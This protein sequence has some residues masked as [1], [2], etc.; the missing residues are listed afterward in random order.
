MTRHRAQSDSNSVQLFP[1][2]AVLLCMMGALILLLV[3]IARNARAQAQADGELA[4]PSTEDKARREE[5]D[6]RREQLIAQRDRTQAELSE[7]RLELGHF[8]EHARALRAELNELESARAQLDQ[9]S[10]TDEQ[11]KR[12][13]AARIA[14]LNRQLSETQAKLL[15]ARQKL[16]EQ[17]SSY[18]IIPYLGPNSTNRPPLYIEC[19][20][21]RVILQPEGVVLLSEDFDGPLGPGNPLAAALRAAREH[22]ARNR[23]TNVGEMGEPY[24]LLLVRPDGIMAY[25]MA[26][27][28]LESWGGDFGYELVDADWDLD[29][30][31]PD[32]EL[33]HSEETA[34]AEARIQQRALAQMMPRLQGR[35]ARQYRAS[36]SGGGIVAA[37]ELPEDDLPGYRKRGTAR[38][39][40]SGYFDP[41]PQASPNAGLAAADAWAAN[42][43]SGNGLGF[44]GQGNGWGTPYAA[45][46]PGQGATGGTS[47]LGGNDGGLYPS[48]APLDPVSR[49]GPLRAGSSGSRGQG[50]GD[51][52]GGR[53]AA[54]GTPGDG[55][56]E[57]S[58][59]SSLAASGGAN[60]GGS[61]ETAAGN[62]GMA[63]DGTS[64][65]DAT[66]AGAGNAADGSDGPAL[67]ASGTNASSAGG[68][69]RT[70]ST[71]GSP[72]ASATP[73]RSGQSAATASAT[74][75]L[76]SPF[77]TYGTS[78]ASGSASSGMS[79][80]SAG[81][82]SGSP[83]GAPT[84]GSSSPGAPSFSHTSAP[85]PGSMAQ[86]RGRDWAVPDEVRRAAP[87]T[88]PVLVRCSQSS[89][90]ILDDD[91]SGRQ[92]RAVPLTEN[93]EDSIDDLMSGMWDHIQSWGLA[94]HGMYWHPQLVLDI[95]PDGQA[96]AADL[97]RLL[98]GSGIEVRDKQVNPPVAR[99][100]KKRWWQR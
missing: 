36:S 95:T 48:E 25:W 27:A 73:S 59:S 56:G 85:P 52:P 82:A 10:S 7:Q 19:R 24:P 96:R 55:S 89:L 38:N 16:A 79:A 40:P 23:R 62:A 83:G 11:Q 98:A 29:F 68:A 90:V 14:D 30:R 20:H 13:L 41:Y 54:G 49:G 53:F 99:E 12:E 66:E 92:V 97:K 46:T 15:R 9:L 74:S 77:D 47:L 94:G 32:A 75:T 80:S 70:P 61:G 58:G 42:Q 60:H 37:D 3:V 22:M 69:A 4:P 8:E 81:A 51:G 43:G 18:S 78:A 93:T 50:F 71:A 72:T 26:R 67:T 33:A 63:S 100:K 88:R 34:V 35:P 45:G 44:Q 86:R 6:W 1:F 17:P 84:G 39:G 5:L 57:G 21:D 2:L 87:V 76:S 65:A 28:A 31:T 91:G 64:A